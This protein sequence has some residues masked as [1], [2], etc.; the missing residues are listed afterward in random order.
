MGL[1]RDGGIRIEYR[2][3]CGGREVR[4]G[5]GLRE[6][7]VSIPAAGKWVAALVVAQ[8]MQIPSAMRV[9]LVFMAADYVTG[10][11]AAYVRR[12]VASAAAWRG[13]VRKTLVIVLLVVLWVGDRVSGLDLRLAQAG[14]IGYIVGEFI[15]IVENV[16]AAGVPV[17]A[18]VVS[19][20]LAVKK[21]QRPATD[22]EIAALSDAKARVT[23]AG[24]AGPS[25]GPAARG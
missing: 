23:A 9:L 6:T 8:W 1:T 20:L 3:R 22:E 5:D 17:P 16:A 15:S 2:R 10:L 25:G 12:E 14:A 18:Q 13:L 7:T 21:I 4:G 19:A 11:A 24:V